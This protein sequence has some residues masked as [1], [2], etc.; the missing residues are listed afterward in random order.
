MN[1]SLLQLRQRATEGTRSC[2]SK[3]EV[4]MV[5]LAM[6]LTS[7]MP[8]CCPTLSCWSTTLDKYYS[9]HANINFSLV[10]HTLQKKKGNDNS[11]FLSSLL[12]PNLLSDKNNNKKLYCNYFCRVNVLLSPFYRQVGD[13]TPFCHHSNCKIKFLTIKN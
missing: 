8:I 12:S 3:E 4:K 1:G 5:P 2:C 9:F 11:W 13:K 7:L 10:L 6:T